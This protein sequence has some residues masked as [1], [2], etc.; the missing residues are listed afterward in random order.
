MRYKSSLLILCLLL[1]SC[2]MTFT[3]WGRNPSSSDQADFSELVTKMKDFKSRVMGSE[4]DAAC[5]KEQLDADFKRMMRSISRDSCSESLYKVDREEF[6]QKVCPKIKVEGYFDTIV[7][8]TIAQEKEKKPV[9]IFQQKIDPKFIAFHNEAKEFIK[10]VEAQL[11]NEN[12][13]TKDRAQLLAE[14][15][16]NVLLP[17]RDLVIVM[18]AYLPKEDDGKIF[19]TT[20]QPYVADTFI[21]QLGP[22]EL[23]LITQGPDPRA[24]P[25]YMELRPATSG[26]SRLS[27]S[28]TDIIRRD[29]I[30]LLK[31]PTSKNYVMALKW[32]TLHMMLSQVYLYDTILGNK[33]DLNIPSSCQTHFLS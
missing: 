6:N 23:G 24:H 10:I 15:V 30:T 33:S 27:F 29:V 20:L 7:K 14:Y 17:I 2:S 1:Q 26:I 3:G 31:A 5:A 12:S 16:E 25:F 21:D 4:K 22:S 9:K 8:D 11:H 28:E 32:M 18:R 13:S 19:Y